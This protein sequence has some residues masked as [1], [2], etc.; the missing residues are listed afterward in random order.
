MAGS[1]RGIEFRITGNGLPDQSKL[2]AWFVCSSTTALKILSSTATTVDVLLPP[3]AKD[4]D[5]K[6][7]ITSGTKFSLFSYQYRT[8]S[9]CSITVSGTGPYTLTKN[10]M[11]T[12]YT[13]NKVEFV[14]LNSAGNPTSSKYL[15][16]INQI[17]GSVSASYLPAGNY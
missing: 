8:N 16:N 5:C 15:M 7:N 3:F 2:S 4:T 11:T 17:S 6:V 14:W 13:Y 12:T 1:Y 10:N 9:T